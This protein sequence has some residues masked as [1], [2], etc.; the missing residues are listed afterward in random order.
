MGK[1]YMKST[2]LTIIGSPT[3][4][5]KKLSN[6]SAVCNDGY[7]AYGL[8][9]RGSYNDG[10][11]YPIAIQKIE[12]FTTSPKVTQIVVKKDN[13]TAKLC[14]HAN[15][16]TFAEGYLYVATMNPKDKTQ[17][18][19]VSK[20]GKV[21]KEYLYRKGS[22]LS[23]FN[24]CTY[25]GKINGKLSFIVGI[26]SSDGRRRY[27]LVH[28]EGN[29]L[30]FDNV[31][32]WSQVIP[33]NSVAN[34]IYYDPNK[35][36][37][38]NTFYIKDSKGKIKTNY[39]Y[40]YKLSDLTKSTELTPNNEYIVAA[41]KNYTEKFEAECLTMIDNKKYIVCNCGSSKGGKYNEDGLFKITE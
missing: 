38:Y 13:K 23:S 19:K 16:I 30:V 6:M 4:D 27:N 1:K 22:S 41:D 33:D 5:G 40:S 29:E 26:G 39:I 14:R 32:Y 37:F 31:T 36:R 8:K 12:K 35:K 9:T 7:T 21:K 11:M 34:A 20:D 2:L 28:I 18:V 24:N 15:D 10:I 25:V 3:V 17:L